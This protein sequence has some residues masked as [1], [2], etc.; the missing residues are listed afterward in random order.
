MFS[1]L[2][3]LMQELSQGFRDNFQKHTNHP[4][5]MIQTNKPAIPWLV[6]EQVL[7]KDSGRGLD[8]ALA[9]YEVLDTL[10]A[11]DWNEDVQSAKELPKTTANDKVLRDQA[12]SR[13]F[14]DFMDAALKGAMAIINKSIPPVNSSDDEMSKIYIH[15]NIFFSEGYDSK[16][17]FECYGGQEAAH[18][19]VSKDLDGISLVESK[20]FDD[21]HTLATLLID[22]KGNRIIAQ[23]IIPGILKQNSESSS[24]LY[25]S[26][27]GGK[28]IQSSIKVEQYAEKLAKSLFLKKHSVLDAENKSHTLMTSMDTKWVK[29]TDER[30]Y[31]LDLY[32]TMPVDSEFLESVKNADVPYPHQMTLLRTELV[33]QYRL[34]KIKA[35]K[36][37]NQEPELL[38]INTDYSTQ[39]K[40]NDSV[41]EKEKDQELSKQLSGFVFAMISQYFM[42]IVQF[43]IAIPVE[44]VSLTNSLHKRGINM[45]YLGKLCELFDN[46]TEFSINQFKFLLKE[47]MVSRVVKRIINRK[48]QSTPIYESATTISNVLNELF[49]I[50]K[51]PF[52]EL[53]CEITR[54]VKARFRY[55]LPNEFWSLRTIALLRSI[56]IKVGIQIKSR[57]YNLQAKEVIFESDILNLVPIL[58]YAQPRTALAPEAMEQG[59]I[60]IAQDKKEV[61]L[62]LMLESTS[63]Y[64]QIYGPI[65]PETGRAYANLAMQYFEL[66]DK[67]LSLN[68]QLKAAIVAE[69]TCGSDNPETLRQFVTVID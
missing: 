43:L 25:G 63:M 6:K 23:S 4:F 11:R 64:E 36:E 47:E 52:S 15:N 40:P 27:D 10:C 5:E 51:E 16:D 28:E 22:Y 20:D 24:I 50:G 48:L 66:D 61:G 42:S 60:Y 45:R 30:I 13:C 55:D 32:R 29:G 46:S 1:T 3:E 44:T 34:H 38:K 67:A 26:V 57:E 56:C 8:V 49:A 37:A 33:D 53:K 58:K 12:V 2:V 35:A 41:E 68:Y 59:R 21:I 39:S 18:V 62:E 19:A 69:R 9:S 14:G 65:H 7:S 54:E 31:V 17:Q